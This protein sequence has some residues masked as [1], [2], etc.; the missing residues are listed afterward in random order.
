[1]SNKFRV[2]PSG[3]ERLA[4]LLITTTARKEGADGSPVPTNVSVAIVK[5]LDG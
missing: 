3:T 1:M 2:C 5:R 4:R